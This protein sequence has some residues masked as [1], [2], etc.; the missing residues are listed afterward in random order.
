M[1]REEYNRRKEHD[2]EKELDRLDR[3]RPKTSFQARRRFE[4]W[5]VRD[6]YPHVSPSLLNSAEFC[7]YIVKTGMIYPFYP[8]KDK[9]KIATYDVSL[10]GRYVDWS[11]DGVGKGGVIK[12]GTKFT[13]SKN[14]I[15]FV[16][17]EPYFRI[18]EYI[19]L[20]FNLKIKN[21][22]KGL[23]LGTGPIVDPGFEGRLSIPLHNLTANDYVLTGGDDLISIEFT[24]L[25]KHPSITQG[26]EPRDS[27]VY[28]PFYDDRN[29]RD[30][31]DVRGY[32]SKAAPNMEVRSSIP[33]VIDEAEEAAS[34]AQSYIRYSIVAMLL[35][36]AVGFGTIGGLVLDLG[37]SALEEY[38]NVIERRSDLINQNQA[39]IDSLEQTIEKMKRNEN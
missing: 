8:E 28:V 27:N 35:T 20:R 5:R 26:A 31:R 38:N 21:V 17:L 2:L 22:Y 29:N 34:N 25:S 39:R 3:R 1:K 32:L 7:D 23:L 16:T 12:E 15:S 24:K 9:I 37:Q 11:K 6:P 19:A 36:V 14:S 30:E 33:S 13:L 18:P 4:K 10:K